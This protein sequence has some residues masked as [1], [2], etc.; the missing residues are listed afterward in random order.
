VRGPGS[1]ATE[2]LVS[3]EILLREVRREL[4]LLAQTAPGAVAGV[5]TVLAIAVVAEGIGPA[6]HLAP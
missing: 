5:S 3:F 6:V 1:G 4:P 2:L